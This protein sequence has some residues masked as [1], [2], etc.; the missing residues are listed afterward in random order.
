MKT[1]WFMA[2]RKY[3]QQ[4]IANIDRH[5]KNKSRDRVMN[6]IPLSSRQVKYLKQSA[7]ERPYEMCGRFSMHTIFPCI[8]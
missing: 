6:D 5:G 2:M 7:N 3:S 4:L 8:S 1:L